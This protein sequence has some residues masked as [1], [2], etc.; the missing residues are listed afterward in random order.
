[1]HYVDR[2]NDRGKK[3]KQT[4]RGLLIQTKKALFFVEISKFKSVRKDENNREN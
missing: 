4:V 1:M 3:K 2:S